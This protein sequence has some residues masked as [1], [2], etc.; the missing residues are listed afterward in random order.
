M[1]RNI[2]DKEVQI[3]LPRILRL[4]TKNYAQELGN[5][6]KLRQQLLEEERKIDVKVEGAQSMVRL[7]AKIIDFRIQKLAFVEE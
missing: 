6:L 2:Q 1:I 3:I 7:K 5:Y 4:S